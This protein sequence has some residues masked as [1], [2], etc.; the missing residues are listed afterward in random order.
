MSH[1]VRFVDPEVL[2]AGHQWMMIRDEDGIYVFVG[3]PFVFPRV[4]EEAWAGYRL[5]MRRA[6]LVA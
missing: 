2:P 3:R 4:L 5:L 6:H 1:S